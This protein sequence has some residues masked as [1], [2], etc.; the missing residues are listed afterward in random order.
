M[1]FKTDR[2]KN[3]FERIAKL[4]VPI[5]NCL[6]MNDPW[7]YRNKVQIPVQEEN[8]KAVLGFYRSHSHDIVEYEA[9]EKEKS[10]HMLFHVLGE[11]YNPQI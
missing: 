4:N 10:F 5:E 7:K 1:K 11:S 9:C 8:G 2:V 3:C 6:G